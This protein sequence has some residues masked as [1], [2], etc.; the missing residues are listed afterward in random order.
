MFPRHSRLLNLPLAQ[1]PKEIS[2]IQEWIRYNN[3]GGTGTPAFDQTFPTL[4]KALTPTEVSVDSGT[5]V[6]YLVSFTDNN[7]VLS[8]FHVEFDPASVTAAG[9]TISD[10]PKVVV[11][12]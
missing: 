8:D 11:A 12:D 9:I 7:G 5:G 6:T 2:V 4:F 3:A 1:T 10:G